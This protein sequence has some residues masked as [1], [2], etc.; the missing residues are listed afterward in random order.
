[1]LVL[2]CGD[3]VNLDRI[4]CMLRDP[5]LRMADAT[6][7]GDI[8][9]IV[10]GSAKMPVSGKDMERITAY[11]NRNRFN[12]VPAEEDETATRDKFRGIA[13]EIERN[14]NAFAKMDFTLH[15]SLP[16][17]P[18]CP[19]DP[20]IMVGSNGCAECCRFSK[21]IHWRDAEENRTYVRCIWDSSEKE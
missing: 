13:K 15:G 2:E 21:G 12:G 9:F 18:R 3:V 5:C 19:R 11:L 1:M 7:I 16:L 4:D 6:L 17:G 8:K 14:E 10:A 20:E